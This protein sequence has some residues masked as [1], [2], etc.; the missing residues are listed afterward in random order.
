[1]D[2]SAHFRGKKITVM[3]LGLLGGVGDIAYLAESG[4]DIIATDLKSEEELRPSLDVLKEFQNIRYTLGQHDPADFQGRDLIIKAPSTPLDSIYIAEARKNGTPV[5]MWAALFATFAREAGAT[6]IGITGTRGKSTVTA[7][8]VAILRADGKKVIE[9]GNVQGTSVLPQLANVTAETIIVLELDSWK[10]QGWGD[11]RMSP[12]IAVFTTLYQDHLN[13]YKEN[14]DAYLADKANIFLYQKEEDTLI[15]GKQ[16]APTIIEKYG[17]AIE[18][19]TLV[20]DEIKLPDTWVLRIPGMH[21]RYDA[22]LALAT[23]RAVGV[24]DDISRK[25]LESFRGV[26]GRLELIAEKRGVKVYN[27]T[28]STTPEATLAALAALSNV[29]HDMSNI[30]LIMGGADKGLDMDVL[31]AKLSEVK[32]VVL[33]AGNGTDRIKNALPSD[34]TIYSSIADAMVAAMGATEPGDTVLFSPAFTSFGMFKNEYDRGDQFV[35]LVK[36]HQA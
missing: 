35:A 33:L 19:K 10:L 31:V 28:T 9:G 15:I 14:T 4:A 18:S 24:S 5:S 32:K 30:V 12:N 22:A 17:E 1:M 16:C 2:A 36:N 34:T 29:G 20:V 27:D 13:Y 26:P 11:A 25:A 23:A 6:I 21:N 7:M 8:I 3:G